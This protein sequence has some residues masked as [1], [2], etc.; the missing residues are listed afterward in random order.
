MRRFVRGVRGSGPIFGGA[1]PRALLSLACLASPLFAQDPLY[2][3]RLP[4]VEAT[5]P[6]PPVSFDPYE[7]VSSTPSPAPSATTRLGAGPLANA[8]QAPL[9]IGAFWAPPQDVSGQNSTLSI[10]GQDVHLGLPLAG[11]L[12]PGQMWIGL[13]TFD[14]RHLATNA[15]LPDSGLDVPG[16][17]WF[18]TLGVMHTRTLSDGKSVGGMLTFGSASDQPFAAGRDLTYSAL[19]FLTFPARNGRDDWALS[20]FYSPTSQ[21]P[22][23]LPGLAYVWRPSSVFQANLGLPASFAYRPT[24]TRTITANYTPVWNVRVELREQLDPDWTLYTG[25]Q[26]DTDIYF[27]AERV[28]D[29]QR[30]FLFEQRLTLGFERRLA[31]GFVLDLA[32]AY[33]FDR[34]L[35][36]ARGFSDARSD[37]LRIGAGPAALVQLRWLR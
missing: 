25:Y 24:P 31:A 36:Q 29:D 15:V 32:M 14:H 8:S 11:G 10:S 12:P 30:F 33:L 23:P 27:L 26:T 21:I 6:V 3:E 18:V 19:A 4:P 5:T 13:L 20:V 17:L 35:F 7:M 2:V 34:E 9:R 22:Y 16:D 37:E 28:D 1:L